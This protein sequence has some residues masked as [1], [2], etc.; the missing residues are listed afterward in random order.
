MYQSGERRYRGF[1]ES[2]RLTPF[3][4]SEK[5]LMLFVASLHQAKLAHGTIKSYLAAIRYAQIAQGLSDP[6]IHSFPQLEYILRGIKKATPTSS[7][8]RLPITPEVLVKLRE[9]WRE[10]PNGRDAKMLWAAS[11]LCFFGFLRSGEIVCP[12]ESQFD[13]GWHLG[14]QDVRTNSHTA[15]SRI[16]VILKGSK[17]DPF[18]QG[19]TLHIGVTGRRICPVAALL[20]YLAARGANPGP[21]FVWGNGKYLTRSTFVDGVR[22]ALTKAGLVGG[23]Y[24]G[25]SFR[26]G[27]ATTA[28]RCGIQDSLI[29]TLGR[30]ESSAYQ[31]YIRT[32]PE[33]LC[34]VSA[35]L[36]KGAGG[37]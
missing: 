18:R 4:T 7:R 20:T 35:T 27:A 21:L 15:P 32:A 30:W 22:R 13:P 1:C 9:A 19:H 17:T 14:V 25:H 31:R 37:K 34:S 23:N 28:A 3:P 10:D 16:E 8:C 6:N 5:I 12:S 24:A 33:T 11:C 36:L 29:K 26:I 2:A